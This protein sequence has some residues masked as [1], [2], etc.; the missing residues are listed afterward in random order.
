MHRQENGHQ[1]NPVHHHVHNLL[2]IMQKEQICDAAYIRGVIG[3]VFMRTN[4]AE[5]GLKK[6]LWKSWF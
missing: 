1:N 6:N 2:N 5:V 3:D 4:P